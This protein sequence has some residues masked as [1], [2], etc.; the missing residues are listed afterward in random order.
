MNRVTLICG[1][2]C[3]GKSTLARKLREENGGVILSADEL[4]L[5]LF[6]AG[7]GE[8]HDEFSGKVKAYLY[9]KADELLK[10]GTDIILDWGFWSRR[11][12]A[13][14][15]KHFKNRGAEVCWHFTTVDD[16]THLK[17]IN[18]RNKKILA[19]ESTDYFVD[20]GLFAKAKFLFDEPTEEE[21][22]ELLKN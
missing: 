11:E 22:A 5:K 8:K 13:Y 2:I 15:T 18:G 7:A 14:V 4:M 20:E 16:E 12:R 1:K 21:K 6:P 3:S 9:D 10:A 19:G 17:F